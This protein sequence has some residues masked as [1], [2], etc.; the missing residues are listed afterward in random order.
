MKNQEEFI[1]ALN[2]AMASM[3]E[4]ESNLLKLYVHLAVDAVNPVNPVAD[5]EPPTDEPPAYE[6]V[7][8]RNARLAKPKIMRWHKKGAHIQE[9]A[10]Q[11]GIHRATVR[12]YLQ[13]YGVQAH[14]KK[15][16]VRAPS[17]AK[18]NEYLK[19]NPWETSDDS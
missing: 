19:Q 18:Q 7:K 8:D 17:E 14:R 11:T 16:P 9:I 10:E 4:A 3:H 6:N 12:R 13:M 5:D 2:D 1:K 15:Y